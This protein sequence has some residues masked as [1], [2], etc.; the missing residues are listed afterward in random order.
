MR[1]GSATSSSATTVPS[2]HND[3]RHHVTPMSFGTFTPEPSDEAMF[4]ADS[5]GNV[6]NGTNDTQTLVNSATLST[7]KDV[8]LVDTN[9]LNTI[10]RSVGR[11]GGSYY[12]S[13][14]F[15]VVA[16]RMIAE[17]CNELGSTAMHW[18]KCGEYF[19]I[20][21]NHRKLSVILKRYFKRKFRRSE[22]V[23]A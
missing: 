10:G 23:L 7:N 6:L 12:D 5:G 4:T 19:W 11:A 21:Q 20:D 1:N 15:P 14:H 9:P 17:V 16:H 8:P 2:V 22:C 13:L 18:T 3:E